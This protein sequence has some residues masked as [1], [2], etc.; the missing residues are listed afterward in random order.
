[1]FFDD[2]F[3]YR[4]GQQQY[5]PRFCDG[6]RLFTGISNEIQYGRHLDEIDKLSNL[7]RQLYQ[8]QDFFFVGTKVFKKV[9]PIDQALDG[10]WGSDKS[11]ADK[12][13]KEEW[14]R[15]LAAEIDP[16]YSDAMDYIIDQPLEEVCIYP[17]VKEQTDHF[18]VVS[19][20]FTN[21]T[22]THVGL[23]YTP[24]KDKYK[25]IGNF[26][27]NRNIIRAIQREDRCR[28]LVSQIKAAAV[29]KDLNHIIM[30]IKEDY[31]HDKEI[32]Q[33]WSEKSRIK[34]RYSLEMEMR[35]EN[36][37][38]ETIRR[39]MWKEFDKIPGKFVSK[40]RYFKSYGSK[41]HRN[42]ARAYQE[43]KLT[44][45]QWQE[46]YKAI[47]AMKIFFLTDFSEKLYRDL[48]R[49][50]NGCKNIK[51]LQKVHE[52]VSNKSNDLNKIHQKQIWKIWGTKAKQK[53]LRGERRYI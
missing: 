37:D 17:Y 34:A 40:G 9:D 6:V 51:E 12:E 11:D 4:D 50:I 36:S 5:D 15:R 30:A 35:E 31:D 52:N 41:W 47:E 38:E 2:D 7:D 33:K 44:Y 28:S 46:A 1:M 26:A 23:G 18:K 22:G 14:E 32:R 16:E 10:D 27:P 21:L 3:E 45:N 48:E 49:S 53:G 25:F 39:R 29:L 20:D 43:L 8:E 13:L 19:I 24:P 42:R